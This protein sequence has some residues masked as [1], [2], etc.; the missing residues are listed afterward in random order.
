[1]ARIMVVGPRSLLRVGLV[2]LLGTIGFESI[3]EADN[4]THLADYIG[5]EPSTDVLI[6]C[7]ARHLESIIG[8][9]SEV[10]ARRPAA[11]IVFVVPKLD[12]EVMSGCFAAGASGY[13][14]E[15]I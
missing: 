15:T 9:V 14:L 10:K 7:L 13:L 11:K 6:I 1:M 5:P 4:I 12:I 8:E 2:S 3:E